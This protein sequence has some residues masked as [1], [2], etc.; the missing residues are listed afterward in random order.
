[1]SEFDPVCLHHG[2]RWSE[3]EF[4]R[5]LYCEVCFKPLTPDECATDSDGEKW[6]VCKGECAKEAGLSGG[7]YEGEAT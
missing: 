2:M 3:H 4:G 6:N 7:Q 1:M 5:C